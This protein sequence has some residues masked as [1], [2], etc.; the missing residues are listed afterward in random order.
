MSAVMIRQEDPDQ[1]EVR[2][3][4][5]AS[6]A[7]LGRLYPAESNHFIDLGALRGNRAAFIVARIEGS[8]VGCGAVVFDQGQDCEIKRMWVDPHWR[9]H[10]VG[11]KLL[12]G[13]LDRARRRGAGVVRLETGIHQP[14]ALQLYRR[15]GFELCGPFSSYQADP[16]SVFMALS[17]RQARPV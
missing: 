7:Y 10:G 15:A 11:G 2:C 6:E 8:A 12:D 16:L 5:V 1:A 4:F 3:F 17:L 9:G 13:L 14:E